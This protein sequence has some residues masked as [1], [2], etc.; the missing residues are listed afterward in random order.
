M[1]RLVLSQIPI[2]LI[3]LNVEIISIECPKEVSIPGE[4]WCSVIV[5]NPLSTNIDVTV[6]IRMDGELI[7]SSR[8]LGN[9][10]PTLDPG[11]KEFRIGVNINND[12]AQNEFNYNSFLDFLDSE[13]VTKENCGH[14]VSEC[15]TFN[16]LPTP[17]VFS[18]E[19]YKGNQLLDSAKVTVALIYGNYYEK[20]F[21]EYYVAPLAAGAT[22]G[23]ATALAEVSVSAGVSAAKVAAITGIIAEV[24]NILKQHLGGRFKLREEPIS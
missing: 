18:I 12:L 24:Y 20:K 11:R 16:F 13:I 6:R 1:G 4:L 8:T 2:P 17:H 5:N 7:D 21:M 3:I 15:Q 10:N 14:R 9:T 22:S 19:I 23:A